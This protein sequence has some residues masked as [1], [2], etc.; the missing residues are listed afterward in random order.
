MYVNHATKATVNDFEF[1]QLSNEEKASFTYHNASLVNPTD[2]TPLPK[3][4]AVKAN[5]V[6]VTGVETVVTLPKRAAKKK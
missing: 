6:V 2:A 5:P 3:K 1:T 4:K